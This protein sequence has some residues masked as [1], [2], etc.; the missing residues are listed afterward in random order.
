MQAA[1]KQVRHSMTD[2][3]RAFF[4]LIAAFRFPVQRCFYLK[5]SFRFPSR[6]HN[7]GKP[8]SSL[9]KMIA[10]AAKWVSFSCN[11]IVLS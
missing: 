6:D 8:I 9:E 4:Y 1:G 5:T 10:S 3:R 11:R 7:L 2:Q